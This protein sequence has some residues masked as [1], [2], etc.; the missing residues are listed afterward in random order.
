MSDS[1][2]TE[3]EEGGHSISVPTHLTQLTHQMVLHALYTQNTP[4]ELCE[5]NK[6]S[7]QH[8]KTLV[9]SPNHLHHNPHA[10]LSLDPCVRTTPHSTHPYPSHPHSSH[11]TTYTLMITPH[12]FQGLASHHTPYLTLTSYTLSL[13]LSPHTTHTK[14]SLLTHYEAVNAHLN[15]LLQTYLYSNHHTYLTLHT[16]SPHKH[17]T[18]HTH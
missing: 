18:P 7:N 3:G 14:L 6:P 4:F 9:L 15:Q 12:R 1:L 2:C 8:C 13:S 17:H 10:P 11:H 16:P 5:F